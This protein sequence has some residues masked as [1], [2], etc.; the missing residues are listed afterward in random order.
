MSLVSLTF[1]NTS[2]GIANPVPAATMD[3]MTLKV[4]LCRLGLSKLSTTTS[5]LIISCVGFVASLCAYSC[6]SSDKQFA[7]LSATPYIILTG[8]FIKPKILV[9]LTKFS[10]RGSVIRST[11]W[12]DLFA[13]R[14][15]A[16]SESSSYR[17]SS[18]F[19]THQSCS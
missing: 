15:S 13:L 11:E 9:Q 7:L 16:V 8:S 12:S 18:I 3:L 14:V 17:I 1:P 6:S 2:T 4:L 19:S 10:Q 5:E